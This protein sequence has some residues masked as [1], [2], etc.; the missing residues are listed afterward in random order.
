MLFFPV[1]LKVKGITPIEGVFVVDISGA[2]IRIKFLFPGDKGY[3]PMPT[4]TPA[5]SRLPLAK[6]SS[7]DT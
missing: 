2:P 1:D 3:P 7:F 6:A 4:S 5:L